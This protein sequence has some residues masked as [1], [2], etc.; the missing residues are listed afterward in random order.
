MEL[1]LSYDPGGFEGEFHALFRRRVTPGFEGLMRGANGTL[2]QSR[3]GSGN[4]AHRLILLPR[5]VRV[6][7]ILRLDPFALDH[8][9]AFPA[10]LPPDFVQGFLHAPRVLRIAPE[11]AKR[12]IPEFSKVHRR[13]SSPID[14]NQPL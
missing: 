9:I 11:V 6:K 10:Q 1:A 3:V 13:A 14:A 8:N 5:I 2:S 4:H 12:L 7:L